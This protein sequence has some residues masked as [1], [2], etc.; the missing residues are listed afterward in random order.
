MNGLRRPLVEGEN[1][2]FTV[3][4]KKICINYCKIKDL[5]GL[6]VPIFDFHSF[7]L[8]GVAYKPEKS[9][10]VAWVAL[11]FKSLAGSKANH[12][13]QKRVVAVLAHEIR[14]LFQT[15]SKNRFAGFLKRWQATMYRYYLPAIAI[16]IVILFLVAIFRLPDPWLLMA[17]LIPFFLFILWVILSVANALFYYFFSEDEK[18]ARKFEKEALKDSRWLNA[19]KI[20]DIPN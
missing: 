7:D 12:I 13:I 1:Y 4:K 5:T 11:N 6:L 3:N 17:N 9:D 10:E 15:K 18:D 8:H 19:V 2:I 16:S 20:E 14:H